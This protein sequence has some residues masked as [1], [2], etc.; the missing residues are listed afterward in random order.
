[1]LLKLKKIFYK[2]KNKD[3][4]NICDN[5]V[6]YKSEELYNMPIKKDVRYCEINKQYKVDNQS[7][8]CFIKEWFTAKPGSTE[9]P[10]LD[11]NLDMEW[12]E[13]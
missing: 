7:C 8:K 2:W 1:M 13:K 9:T 6:F 12:T 10:E 5:C 11:L 3:K 4:T